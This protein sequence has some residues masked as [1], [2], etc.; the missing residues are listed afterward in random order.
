[1]AA[2]DYLAPRLGTTSDRLIADQASRWSR[3][4]ADL[5]LAAGRLAEAAEAYEDLASL[6]ADRIARGELLLGAAEAH[7][8]LNHAQTGVTAA[9]RGDR[10]AR[11]TAADP[12]IA[13]A[14]STGSRTSTW[15]STIPTR[16]AGCC[17]SLLGTDASVTEDPDFDVRVRIAL[18]QVETEHGDPARAA[19]YLEEARELAAGLDLRK[20]G[21]YFDALSKARF[22]A[23]DT[24]GAIRAATE[25]LALF[26]ASEQEVQEAMLENALAMSFVRLGNLARAAELAAQAVAIAERLQ[27]LPGPGPL[28]RHAGDDQPRPRRRRRCHPARRPR[29]RA[30]GGAR[31][32][33]RP[34]R[35]PDHPRPGAVPGGPARTRP[36]PPGPMPPAS[37]ASSHRRSAGGGSTR[38]GPSRWRP[39]AG[40]RGLRGHAPGALTAVAAAFAWALKRRSATASPARTASHG[41]LCADDVRHSSAGTAR[42]AA[43]SPSRDRPRGDDGPRPVRRPAAGRR[44]SVPA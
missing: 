20:R 13:S 16:P 8:K 35:R 30:R 42:Q 4:D 19:L 17:L 1:M 29:A 31:A 7:C 39:R 26:R 22:A 14:P 34:G 15:P 40:T 44:S 38:P 43:R 27:P 3:V 41:R 21:T 12:P 32:G 23:N 9:G 10:A 28:P 36:K 25:A 2:L 33:E 18:A 5:H 11:A 37:P 6:A 24:E